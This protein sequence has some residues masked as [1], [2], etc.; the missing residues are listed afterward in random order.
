M[1]IYVDNNHFSE[2]Y[3]TMGGR[4][5]L[6]D[7]VRDDPVFYKRRADRIYAIIKKEFT[8]QN[9][10]LE[11]RF[12]EDTFVQRIKD[13]GWSILVMF[14]VSLAAL[15]QEIRAEYPTYVCVIILAVFTLIFLVLS[16]TVCVSFSPPPPEPHKDKK[17]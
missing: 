17:E 8:D 1:S 5:S 11:P 9:K 2:A 4:Q 3:T 15:I 7:K 13:G 16:Y 10:P 14:V 12:I 6:R